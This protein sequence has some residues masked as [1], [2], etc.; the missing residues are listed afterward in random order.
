MR[1]LQ[2]L[3]YAERGGTEQHVQNLVRGLAD[4]ASFSLLSPPGPGLPAG[5]GLPWYAFPRLDHHLWAGIRAFRRGLRRALAEQQPDVIHI[6]AAHEL[7]L[8]VKTVE[9]RVPVVLTVHGYGQAAPLEYRLAALTARAA[10]QAVICVSEEERRRL[11]ASGLPAARVHRIYNGVADPWAPDSEAQAR[12]RAAEFRRQAL[13]RPGVSGRGLGSDN[14]LLIGTVARL[15]PAKGL[16]V[17]IE[18]FARM[19]RRER[20]GLAIVGSGP[21]L[22][23]LQKLSTRRQVADRIWFAGAVDQ[24]AQVMSALDIFVLPTLQEALGLA[25][26]EAMASGV[27]VVATRVGGLPEAVGSAPDGAGGIL[28]PPGDARALAAALDRLAEDAGL[29]RRLGSAGRR[30]YEELFTVQAFAARTL[31]VYQ[32][33][34]RASGGSG[35]LGKGDTRK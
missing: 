7:V 3:P 22:E 21:Q 12:R 24:A 5:W 1:V 4:Q 25:A 16:R 34:I 8:L 31:A 13:E 19:G 18:A 33:T 15:V 23:E 29:R 14:P 32:A 11:M 17:L 10:A 6:H 26:I 35:G 20:C 9:R 28:V 30:R 2:I 27:P